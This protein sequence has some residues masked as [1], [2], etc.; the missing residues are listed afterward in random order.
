M[1]AGCEQ[2]YRSVLPRLLVMHYAKKNCLK[3]ET[4]TETIIGLP[5]ETY[6]ADESWQLNQKF[7]LRI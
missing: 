6:I 2:E 4:N 7:R 5:I 1:A 3:V